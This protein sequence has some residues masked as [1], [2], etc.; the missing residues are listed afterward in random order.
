[1]LQ[2][3][4]SSFNGDGRISLSALQGQPIRLFFDINIES[5]RNSDTNRLLQVAKKIISAF[6]FFKMCASVFLF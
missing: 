2:H 3:L 4:C 1:M 6:T 5:I